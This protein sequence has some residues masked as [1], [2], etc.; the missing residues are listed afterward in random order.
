[1]ASLALA[2]SLVVLLTIFIGPIAYLTARLHFPSF[3]VYLLSLLSILNG[4][5]F[6]SIALPIWYLGLVP[7]YF[8]YISIQR[9]RKNNAQKKML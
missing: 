7:I 4:L 5:W 1:M 2:A 3:I 6:I 8:G 9:A